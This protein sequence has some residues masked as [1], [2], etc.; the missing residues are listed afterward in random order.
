MKPDSIKIEKI[1]EVKKII[2]SDA[3]LHNYFAWPT[4]V[5]LKDGRIAVGCSGN[6]LE[7][8]CPFG[9]GMV[10]FS[11]D[12]GESYTPP[13]NVIKTPLDDR[14]VG[15]CTFGE[16]GLIVTSF[17]NTLEFQLSQGTCTDYMREYLQSV[18]QGEEEKFYGSLL[19][20][21]TDNGKTF[22]EIHKS[23][24]TSPHGPIELADGTVLWVGRKFSNCNVPL[25]SCGDIHAFALST[26]D[27]TMTY[28]GTVENVSDE[29]GEIDFHEPYAIQLPGGKIICHIRAERSGMFTTYQTESTD[30][31][32]TWTKPRKIFGDT[33][34]APS[35]L[36]RLSSGALMCVYGHR[37]GE[38]DFGIYAAFSRDEG[39]TWSRGRSVYSN[40]VSADLGY[41]ASVE[42][43]NGNILTVFYAH[44]NEGEPAVIL[45]QIWKPVFD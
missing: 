3:P 12:N 9:V 25:P 33:E 39:E 26:Q 23:P 6:R 28:R 7:H 40:R 32:Y 41:P 17:N 30:G 11:E 44:H 10:A 13:V 31:G 21:S 15:L 43:E 29:K 35:H 36:L 22:G 16:S 42:L 4:A 20:I 2:S 19:R 8:I 5:K 34:G 1:G 18:S 24:V 37:S 38:P 14:D 45:Q 27:G